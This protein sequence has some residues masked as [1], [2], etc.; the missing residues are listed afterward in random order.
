MRFLKYYYNIFILS[1]IILH[2]VYL[3]V[4]AAIYP[5]LRVNGK[6]KVI[7]TQLCNEAGN[8][9]QLRGVS[10]HGIQWFHQ[11]YDNGQA[12]KDAAKYWGADVIRIPMYIYEDGYLSNKNI[13]PED[14]RMLID[15]YVETCEEAGIYAIIDWH[16][17]HPGD[18]NY[19][20]DS[21]KAFFR[22]MSSKHANKKNVL[23]EICNEPSEA[24][25]LSSENIL[26]ITVT[27]HYVE[28]PEIKSYAEAIIPII[29][30]NDPNAVILVGT[31]SW[32][33]LGLSR[34]RDWHEIANNKLQFDNVMYVFHFYAV[35]HT[36][37]SSIN[38]AAKVLP[39][40]CTEWASSDWM[41]NSQNDFTKGQLWIDMMAQNKIS[42]SYWN[43][44]PGKSI[45]NMF[46]TTTTVSGPFL[47]TGTNVTATGKKVYEWL[48]S[49][50]DEWID[51]AQG[52]TLPNDT[53]SIGTSGIL[54]EDCEHTGGFN[55]LGGVWYTY[56]DNS[57]G[58]K[59]TVQPYPLFS[60]TTGGASGSA[61]AIKVSY[62]ID[63]GSLTYPGFV[64]VGC[65]LNSDQTKLTD[66]S[67]ASSISFYYK[68]SSSRFRIETSDITDY[69]FFGKVIPASSSWTR[70]TVKFSD[71]TREW[72]VGTINL[73]HV[74]KISWQVQ[75]PNGSGE[76]WLD[77]ITIDGIKTQIKQYLYNKKIDEEN[78]KIQ[79]FKSG[80][81]LVI[82][83]NTLIES[84]VKI[85]IYQ[86][87]GKQ[88]KI[89]FNKADIKER[90]NIYLDIGKYDFSNGIYYLKVTTNFGYYIN[91]IFIK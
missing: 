38:D 27:G 28:W 79:V 51:T 89:V 42:W 5:P 68:G 85:E 14:F 20:I 53:S 54:I 47:P 41:D 46:D 17:H 34:N 3:S 24:G 58:G 56:N 37:L 1:A 70:I 83:T 2:F 77:S 76:I 71:L 52:G 59:S 7:G 30:A 36:F 11:Y 87:N 19:S 44:A 88:S 74:T 8:P 62:T 86:I 21:A 39:L 32:S 25:L 35:S 6:L 33:T 63:K 40:F 12:I 10:M 69:D 80:K 67:N 82:N 26:G 64:G 31:P 45:M 84:P 73:A 61:N 75:G 66:L 4:N 29:R 49:P 50:Q 16:V 18:P 55:L 81:Y 13:K 91:K 48:T 22:Y 60:F 65:Y 23:Y 43:F 72:G 57:N 78:K 90:K 15:K 9:I